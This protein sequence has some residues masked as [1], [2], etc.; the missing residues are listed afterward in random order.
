MTFGAKELVQE[1]ASLIVAA[2]TLQRALTATVP[3][4]TGHG[5]ESFPT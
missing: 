4:D 2:R 1:R 5:Q 3:D